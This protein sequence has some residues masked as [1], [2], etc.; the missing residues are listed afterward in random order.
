LIVLLPRPKIKREQKY[1]RLNGIPDIACQL[2]IKS[3]KKIASLRLTRVLPLC[4][5]KPPN[6]L[7]LQAEGMAVGPAIQAMPR[8]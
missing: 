6:F 5:G 3:R 4:F 7:L 2:Q 8:K 1:R